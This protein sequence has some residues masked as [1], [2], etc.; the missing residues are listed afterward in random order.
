V[1]EK[2]E[3]IVF[4]HSVSPIHRDEI[5][6]IKNLPGVEGIAEVMLIWDFEPE[7][8]V[9]G[10]GVDPANTFGPGRLQAV[11][12]AGRYLQPGDSSV[13]IA[14]LTYAQQSGLHLGDT[15]MIAG[16]PFQIIGLGD[17]TRAGQIAN[18]NLFIPLEDARRLANAAPYVKSVH[19][20]RPDDANLLFIKANQVNVG[21]VAQGAKQILGEQ[22]IV[23]TSRSFADELGT[24]FSLIDHFGFV[25]GLVA[26]LF[27]AGVLIRLNASGIWE[28]RREVGLMR[29]VGWRKRD[30]VSQLWAETL[31]LALAGSLLGLA[32]GTIFIWLIAQSKVTIPVP[33]EL[34]PTP[35]FLPGGAKAVSVV[36]PFPV[37]MTVSLVASTLGLTLFIATLIGVWL[38]NRISN[39]KPAEVLRS[40]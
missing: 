5:E 32:L 15:M 13:A 40:E 14:D 9:A 18:A 24:L 37:Q 10:L 39:L 19:P 23:T 17:T 28:R 33:W 12:T 3:G 20:I 8:F 6:Q 36:I 30:V 25:V 26:F 22:G 4:P 34:S 35:H 1:P 38:S 21:Q 2:F 29:A 11:I 16:I 7:G 31:V 27:A